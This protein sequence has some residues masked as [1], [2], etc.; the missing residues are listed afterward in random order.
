MSIK[1]NDKIVRTTDC[2][3]T[4]IDNEV[5]LM[6]INNGRYYG[7]NSTLGRIWTELENATIVSALIEKL[8]SQYQG[9]P[10]QIRSDILEVLEQMQKNKLIQVAE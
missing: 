4:E 8:Q 2:I 1:E 3:S 7:L 9:E 10:E 5:V 6:H